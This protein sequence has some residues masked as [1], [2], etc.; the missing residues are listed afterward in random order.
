MNPKQLAKAFM[1]YIVLENLEIYR[2]HFIGTALS[3]DMSDDRKALLKFLSGLDKNEIDIVFRLIKA[4]ETDTVSNMLGVLDGSTTLGA[5]DKD[6]VLT[7]DG[8]TAKLNGSLQEYF[9]QLDDA[10]K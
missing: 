8:S 6:F 10:A 4:V 5:L 3:R 2:R 1:K 7:Y 9:L